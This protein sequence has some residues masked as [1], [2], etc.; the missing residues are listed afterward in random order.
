MA[1]WMGVL[2][3]EFSESAPAVMLL[4]RACAESLVASLL[5]QLARMLPTEHAYGLSWAAA[6]FDPAQML[7]RGFPV[8]QQIADLFL[9][10]REKG[11]EVGQSLTLMQ[12]QGVMPAAVLTPD[13][14]S[15]SATLRAIPL[16]LSGSDAAIAAARN[17][18]ESE[19]YG[20]GLADAGIV[21]ALARDLD[22]RF[23]H[24]RWMS[25][26]DLA[27]MMA[28]QLEHVGF[29]PAW[30]L[31]EELLF[32]AAPQALVTTTSL[33][34][35]MRLHE[36][37]VLLEFRT[38]AAYARAQQDFGLAAEL[39]SYLES[40][41]EFRQ[42]QALFAAHAIET[43]IVLPDAAIGTQMRLERD[44]VIERLLP[45]E[46]TAYILQQHPALGALA[47]TGTDALGRV[48]EQRYPLSPAAIE[49]FMGELA[50]SGIAVQRPG[51]L[52]LNAH[53]SDLGAPG[54]ATSG[55]H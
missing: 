38:Y 10:G 35:S 54:P 21:M 55:H 4:T 26:L 9:A 41:H 34:Q 44:F 25:L 31:I 6:M 37:H 36:D 12:H 40:V 50:A 17:Q 8:H 47:W 2:A 52:I 48:V 49:R 32:S 27:A 46:S 7:R 16:V 30:T 53:G 33:G 23:E 19:L 11:L 1:V 5:K 20:E 13:G 45:E 43:R 3:L 22:V 29:T 28:A 39:S 15:G 24:V 42:L 51:G 14:A 18:L